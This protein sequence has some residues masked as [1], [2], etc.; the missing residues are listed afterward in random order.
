MDGGPARKPAIVLERRAVDLTLAHPWT[1]ARGSSTVKRNVLVRAS[2]DITV[3]GGVGLGE[4]APNTRYGEDWRSVLEALDRMAPL[5]EDDP[6]RLSEVV[7]RLHA[8]APAAHAAR[9]AVDIAL[10]DLAGK[11]AGLPLWRML[12]ADPARMPPTSDSIGLDTIPA[13]QEKVRAAAER[14]ILKVKLGRADD[15]AVIEAI[16]AVTDKPL[17]VDANEGWRDRQEAVALIRWME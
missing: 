1:I 4:A 12:G 10:H 11:R 9:A 7:A 3:A 2:G 17:Y 13:M 6:V 16:R 15:R 8:A 14:P 5:V